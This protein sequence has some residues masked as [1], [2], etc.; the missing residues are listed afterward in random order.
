MAKVRKATNN[1]SMFG[2]DKR[3]TL[4]Y[5]C[6]FSYIMLS[7]DNLQKYKNKCTQ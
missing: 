6:R 7:G 4:L 2:C 1:K 5:C 3:R